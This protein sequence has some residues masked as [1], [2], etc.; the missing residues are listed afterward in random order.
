[1]EEKHFQTEEMA[2]ARFRGKK[3]HCVRVIVLPS[4]ALG[5]LGTPTTVMEKRTFTTLRS[6]STQTQWQMDWAAWPQCHRLS[7][8]LH[9]LLSPSQIQAEQRLLVPKLR[10]NWWHPWAA[11][12]PPRSTSCTPTMLTRWLAKDHESSHFDPWQKQQHSAVRGKGN[13]VEKQQHTSSLLA[14]FVFL[15]LLLKPRSHTDRTSGLLDSLILTED[16]IP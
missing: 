4:F 11:Q 15:F 16:P 7:P 9:L 3:A 8:W 13:P 10:L 12:L 5:V 6:S 14:E 1:M 2:S